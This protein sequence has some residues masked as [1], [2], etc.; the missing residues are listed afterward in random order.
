MRTSATPATYEPRLLFDEHHA[1]IEALCN[2][3]RESLYKD[4][5]LEVIASY[6]TL[7]RAVLE[8]MRAEED[9]I[10]PAYTTHAPKDAAVIVATHDELRRRLFRLG[11]DAELHCVR[12]PS[13]DELIA[14]LRAHAAHENREMYPWA[15]SHL[16]AP[17]KRRLF[18]RMTESQL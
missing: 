15:E 16:P 10:L 4:D 8:H 2:A 11:V 14:A 18:A 3:L 9:T 6:R 17:T 1:E 5:P 13:I 12:A 7:E